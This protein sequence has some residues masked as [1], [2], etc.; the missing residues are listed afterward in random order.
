MA[1][2]EKGVKDDEKGRGCENNNSSHRSSRQYGRLLSIEF[3]ASR[4]H[5]P[6]CDAVAVNE[7][8][9]G[10]VPSLIVA[11]RL[12]FMHLHL[13]T[14]SVEKRGYVIT[15]HLLV[16]PYFEWEWLLPHG[17]QFDDCMD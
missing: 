1:V 15:V 5:R 8:N 12:V 7:P 6:F 16:I 9:A 13:R 4:R 3:L 14:L 11:M 17:L 10:Y 2:H